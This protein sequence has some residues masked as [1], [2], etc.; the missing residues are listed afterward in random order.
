MLGIFITGNKDHVIHHFDDN[1][2]KVVTENK[3]FIFGPTKAQTFECQLK[4]TFMLLHSLSHSAGGI[5]KP[6]RTSRTFRTTTKTRKTLGLLKTEGF[7]K[8]EGLLMPLSSLP[9]PNETETCQQAKVIKQHTEQDHGISK[10]SAD[11]K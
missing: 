8:T 10:R 2:L 5:V 3:N 7:L 1:M 11:S 6:Q 4:L 9:N